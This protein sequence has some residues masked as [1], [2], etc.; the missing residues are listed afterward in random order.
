[1]KRELPMLIDRVFAWVLS[2]LLLVA[3]LGAQ[4]ERCSQNNFSEVLNWK[5]NFKRSASCSKRRRKLI[6]F[7]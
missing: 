6:K 2:G 4:F 7:N 1:M 5:A 3:W